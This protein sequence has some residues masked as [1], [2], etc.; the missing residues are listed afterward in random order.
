VQP[1][2]GSTAV[3]RPSSRTLSAAANAAQPELCSRNTAH[4]KQQQRKESAGRGTGLP[5][6]AK[7]IEQPLPPHRPAAA[8]A[9]AGASSRAQPTQPAAGGTQQTAQQQPLS[10]PQ[11]QVLA[12]ARQQLQAQPARP[13]VLESRAPVGQLSP[14]IEEASGFGSSCNTTP[15]TSVTDPTDAAPLRGTYGSSSSCRGGNKLRGAGAGAAAA[16]GAASTATAASRGSG[17]VSPAGAAGVAAQEGSGMSA[18]SPDAAVPDAWKTAVRADS[19]KPMRS[20]TKS[21]P[22]TAG[23]KDTA[24]ES[25]SKTTTSSGCKQGSSNHEKQLTKG[26]P[27]G[28]HSSMQA[29]SLSRLGSSSPKLTSPAAVGTRGVRQAHW[30]RSSWDGSGSNGQQ[31]QLLSPSPVDLGPRS[32][33]LDSLETLLLDASCCQSDEEHCADMLC[34][35]NRAGSSRDGGSE[36]GASGSGSD[37]LA[38]QA[39]AAA[40]AG[41]AGGVGLGTDAG[42]S[43]LGGAGGMLELQDLLAVVLDVLNDKQAADKRCGPS[44]LSTDSDRSLHNRCCVV[45]P[46]ACAVGAWNASMLSA[47]PSPSAHRLHVHIWLLSCMCMSQPSVYYRLTCAHI[48]IAAVGYCC[49]GASGVLVLGGNCPWP[50]HSHCR[51]GLLLLALT[52]SWHQA[53][54]SQA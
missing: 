43:T 12:Q 29:R 52:G 25:Q 53:Y 26:A 45:S 33:S 14:I 51:C 34:G 50:G 27:A 44:H 35:G 17:W 16:V 40:A 46:F 11:H 19:P 21:P 31:Q 13:P 42:C 23:G 32:H 8:A 7:V 20:G 5:A 22:D 15:R 1:S 28:N 24:P 2:G 36:A 6:A 3:R 30:R 54:H 10:V 18:D 9:A 39:A 49:W 38:L 37:R 4:Q 47:Q 48:H 41:C